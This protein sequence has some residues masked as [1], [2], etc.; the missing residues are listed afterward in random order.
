MY[1][2]YLIQLII[3]P[4]NIYIGYTQD[5]KK[6][7]YNHNSGTTESTAKYVPWKLISYTAF[8]DKDTSIEF[9]KYL[10]SGSG[11]A[12]VSKRFLATK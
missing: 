3:Y 1:Y 4:N 11:R 8:S 2:V 6:L 10:K 5:I 9:E 12:F 7:I